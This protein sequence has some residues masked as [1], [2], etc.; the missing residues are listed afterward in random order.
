MRPGIRREGWRCSV[1][2]LG[3][4]EA[5]AMRPGIPGFT[6]LISSAALSFNEAQAMRP[7]IQVPRL[8]RGSSTLPLQ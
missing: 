2:T 5:Q 3:F 4:N 6:G 1:L 8:P 7:G